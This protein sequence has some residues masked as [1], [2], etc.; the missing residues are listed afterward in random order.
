MSLINANSGNWNAAYTNLVTNSA[1]YLSSYDTTIFAKVSSQAYEL[2][3][4]TPGISAI[5][6][7]IGNNTIQY[8]AY[9][10]ILGGDNNTLS[11]D[12]AFVLGSNINATIPDYTYVNNLSSVGDVKTTTLRANTI[13]ADTSIGIGQSNPLYFNLDVNGSGTGTIGNS[14][15]DL[16]L[17]SS[18]SISILPN[19]YLVLSPVDNI[20]VRPS[21]D[22]TTIP[23]ERLTVVGG[24]SATNIIYA[25]GGNS[26][27]WNSVYSTVNTN[28][29][30]YI[31]DGGN[32]KGANIMIGT[33]DNF[34]LEFETNALRKLIITRT[35]IISAGTNPATIFNSG[36]ATGNLSFA[37]GSGRAFGQRSFAQGNNTIAFGSNSY[38]EGSATRASG[39]SSHAEGTSTQAT[40]TNSHAE[41]SG[42]V[43]SGQQ[44]HAEGTNTT[45]SGTAS[46]AEG[47][48]T[49]STGNR[50]HAEGTSTIAQGTNSHA[51]GD[52]TTASGSRSHTEGI[53]TQATND[54]THAE[55]QNSQATGINAHAEGFSTVASGNQS[56]AEGVRSISSGGVSHAEG[57]DTVASGSISTAHGNQSIASGDISFVAG[58]NN[59]AAG[60]GSVVFG[61]YAAAGKGLDFAWVSDFSLTNQVSTTRSEQF[62]VSAAGGIYLAE[63]VGINTD[64]IDNALTVNGTISTGKIQS[65]A[66]IATPSSINNQT[67]TTY[68]LSDNDNGRIITLSASSAISLNV[69]SGLPVGFNV[70]AI[71]IGTGQ[72]SVSAGNG[73]IINS[74]GAKTKIASQHS[75]A[76]IVSYDTNIFNLAGNLTT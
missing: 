39:S 26:D 19:N 73:V 61:A 17:G 58:S 30:N 15:G 62:M 32:T 21:S 64:N 49:Q 47:Q 25:S 60:S 65:G 28:S 45:A 75:S 48:S 52:T 69:P 56:H 7:T 2:V 50:S 53:N 74:D 3:T 55:G 68:V 54:N 63:R 31:L 8:G 66:F 13:Q 67:V 72:V 4:T 16:G 11:A 14:Y 46:H 43:A 27:Q 41:G 18:G 10:A 44:S 34:D 22:N 57:R 33:N 6:P 24:I 38:V 51:E 9:S 29:A 5:K 76:S 70:I 20:I 42:A 12:N 36:S 23:N 1:S 40:N 71:Q 37:I 35:G 59:F